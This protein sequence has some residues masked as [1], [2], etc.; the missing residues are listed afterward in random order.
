[1]L[2]ANWLTAV[3][4]LV[5][6]L[7]ASWPASAQA[8]P[9]WATLIPFKK[10]EA[11]PN[12]SYELE[13]KH[14]PWIIMAASFAGAAAE[15]QAHDLVMELRQKFKLE[16]YTFRQSFD[17]SKPVEGNGLSKYGGRRRMRN[18]YNNRFD[19]IAV[20]VG[21]F[22]TLDD[23][24]LDKTLERLKYARP[25]VFQREENK[26][27]QRMNTIR[28]FY[29]VVV[30]D[31][32]RKSKGPMGAAFATRNPLLPKELFTAK[33]LDPF[34]AG[35][36]RD[37]PHSLLNCP[38]RYTVRVATFRGV[39]TMKPAEFERLTTQERKYSKIDE[40][41][42]KASELCKQL[43]QQ[44]VEAY[45]FHDRTE[46]IVTIGSF[47]EV[48][49]P[50]IDGKI[51]INPAIHRIMEAYGPIKQLKPGTNMEEVYARVQNGLRFDPQPLPVEVP[52]QSIAAA[53]NPE[54]SPYR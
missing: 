45:E 3:L 28:D 25:Q 54:N 40:A 46:S 2:R 41:A 12:K 29:R 32:S 22:Q 14:G 43:R 34:V 44:G 21:N 48:G 20:V 49:Q 11:D 47:A 8:A 19:E 16:A 37:L 4:L 17:F 13:E 10:I 27:A 24:Q 23:P 51:E 5:T 50:R 7:A 30:N 15:Q 9:P 42:L 38:G 53:Y 26:S 39:D 31:P 6:G 35:M 18:L 36:N 33:G 52:K 1:M